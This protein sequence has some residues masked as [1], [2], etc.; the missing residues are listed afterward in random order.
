MAAPIPVL[1]Y[2]GLSPC[3]VNFEFFKNLLTTGESIR[4]LTQM[5]NQ[6][7]I[8]EKS[9]LPFTIYCPKK[10]SIDITLRLSL[11]AD[12]GKSDIEVQTV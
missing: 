7:V 8:N 4:S 5:E 2:Q 12:V 10:G 1:E 3:A 6:K 9:D 11:T